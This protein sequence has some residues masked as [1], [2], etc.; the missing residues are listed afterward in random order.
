MLPQQSRDREI[1]DSQ[2]VPHGTQGAALVFTAI[3]VDHGISLVNVILLKNDDIPA[4]WEHIEHLLKYALD[5]SKWSD[6][7]PIET[8][9]NDLI[10][11]DLQCWIVTNENLIKGVAVTQDIEYPLGKSLLVFFLGG[12]DMIC[13][14][15][16]L[17]KQFVSHAKS[18]CYKWIDACAR[19]GLGKKY[20]NRLGFLELNNH[21][22]YEV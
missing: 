14:A 5:K 18:N 15:D 10:S 19:P 22:C 21:Y 8:L 9:Y 13:W 17:H 20:L 3:T 4:L 7:Y 2:M 1:L 6:R 16:E 11:D 12:E